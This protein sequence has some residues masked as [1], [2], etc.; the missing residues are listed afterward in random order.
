MIF[1]E[2]CP[3]PYEVLIERKAQKQ[4][5]RLDDV[6]RGRVYETLKVIRDSGFTPG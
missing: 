3:M 4:L 2:E 1:S 6:T 5:D